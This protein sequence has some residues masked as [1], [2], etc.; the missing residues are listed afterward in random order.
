[1]TTS[2]RAALCDEIQRRADAEG[3]AVS[4][5]ALTRIGEY[6]EV[7]T[8]WNGTINLTALPLTLPLAE[9]TLN[10]LVM[11]PVCAS[12]LVPATGGV[13][14][15]LGTGGGSPA[16]PLWALRPEWHLYMVESRSRKCAFLREAAR[17]M[18]ALEARVYGE[19]FESCSVAT[20]SVDLVSMRAVRWEPVV[21]GL[22][23]RILKP[24]GALLFFG[25]Q[26]IDQALALEA[27]CRLPGSAPSVAWLLRRRS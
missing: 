5:E 12:R 23:L 20:S 22:V 15:D 14:C 6:L 17:R 25:E 26:P 16:L 18:G 8:L 11:E 21:A 10:R 3:I 19:R 27:H 7:L 1:M 13:W 9:E 4:D 24:T 2:E